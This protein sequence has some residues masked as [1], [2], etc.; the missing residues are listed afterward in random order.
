MG[1]SVLQWLK[2]CTATPKSVSSIFSHAFTI[3]FE[4]KLFG[5]VWILLHLPSMGY[6]FFYLDVL[7]IKQPIKVDM[8]LKKKKHKQTAIF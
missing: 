1:V 3:T 5:K 4:L 2:D 6:L 7:D 8:P